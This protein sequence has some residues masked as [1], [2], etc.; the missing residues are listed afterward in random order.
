MHSSAK[1][2]RLH[3]EVRSH[4]LAGSAEA[5]LQAAA[6]PDIVGGDAGKLERKPQTWD[7]VAMVGVGA[8]RSHP[9]FAGHS[10]RE[11]TGG[12]QVQQC[13]RS[14]ERESENLTWEETDTTA[15]QTFQD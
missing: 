12:S 14:G 7:L 11:G 13:V 8:A 3:S 9:I 4:A 15:V 2:A 6:L 10:E 5:A 1:P